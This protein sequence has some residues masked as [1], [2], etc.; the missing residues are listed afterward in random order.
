MAQSALFQ[1]HRFAR[2]GSLLLVA[3]APVALLLAGC[4]TD[5]GKADKTI[6]AQLDQATVQMSGSETDRT[7]A[8]HDLGDA[9]R[10]TTASSPVQLRAK[11]LLADSELQLAQGMTRQIATNSVQIER[12]AR[13]IDLLGNQIQSNNKTITAMTKADP[14]PLQ[15]ALSQKKADVTG[16]DAKPD[17]FK[18]DSG[19]LA[20]LAADDAALRDLQGK[21][22][23]SQDTIKSESDQRNQLLDQ[24]DKATQ[25]SQH[26]QKQKSV[27][28]YVQGSNARKQAADL[29][30]KIDADNATLASQQADLT[31]LQGQQ[32]SLN[33]AL[34]AFDAKGAQI[35]SDWKQVQAE[36]IEL[37]EDSRKILGD[38]PV[39]PPTY[40][41]TG[42]LPTDAT[43]GSKASAI[44][45]LAKKNHDLRG[46]AE[47]HFN[48]AIEKYSESA[49]QAN[50]IKA[51]LGSLAAKA[52]SQRPDQVAYQQEQAAFDPATYR[53]LQADA[54]LQAA[55]FYAATASEAKVRL[56]GIDRLKAIITDARLSLPATLDDSDGSI[57]DQLK[58]AQQSAREAF[59]N[60]SDLLG[61]LAD[62][63]APPE[64]KSGAEIQQIFTQYGLYLLEQSTG[65]PAD[66]QDAAAHL[67]AARAAVSTA[68]SDGLTLPALPAELSASPAGGTGR[69]S[70]GAA[71]PGAESAS[72]MFAPR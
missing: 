37:T 30:V 58:K 39:T 45:A 33:S 54:Q 43:I 71:G 23:Q 8:N 6:S 50:S 25:Q 15:D 11:S 10:E 44:F 18:S 20:S 61:N 19:T 9:A 38:D 26:E 70:A 4:D 2:S 60:A 57:A 28:L 47:S 24:A 14:G 68:V 17:W 59:K 27:D 65:D 21:I 3:V 34:K 31:V 52:D 72:P 13:E 49:A 55:E 67:S 42:D 48:S 40:N 32:D 56:D 51:D 36:Q 12:L 46:D 7:S 69:G 5:S 1:R 66:A 62:G 22:G 53:F 35:D 41:R 63:S 29:T 16:S 64:I